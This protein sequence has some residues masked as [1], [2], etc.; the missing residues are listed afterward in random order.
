VMPRVVKVAPLSQYRLHVEFDDLAG[1]TDLSGELDGEVFQPLRDEAVFREVTVD[2]SARYA[3]QT[4]PTSRPTPCTAS[5]PES[6]RLSPDHRRRRPNAAPP[7]NRQEATE[8]GQL[9]ASQ[10]GSGPRS[11]PRQQLQHRPG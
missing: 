6:R 4:A 7:R 5:L 11:S 10:R 8:P 9:P 3:G 2:E 1:T